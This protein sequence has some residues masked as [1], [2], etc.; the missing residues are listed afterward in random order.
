MDT[1]KDGFSKEDAIAECL[2]EQTIKSFERHSPMTLVSERKGDDEKC[3]SFP[4]R[5][6]DGYFPRIGWRKILAACQDKAD[7]IMECK[8]VRV[9]TT[10]DERLATDNFTH[11]ELVPADA[12]F[13][14]SHD[15]KIDIIDFLLK[16]GASLSTAFGVSLYTIIRCRWRRYA[17]DG[18]CCGFGFK[19]K[20]ED[21]DTKRLT[22]L[23]NENE[24]MKRD[25]NMMKQE[26]EQMRQEMTTQTAYIR[27]T[28][29]TLDRFVDTVDPNRTD[30]GKVESDLKQLR[31]KVNEGFTRLTV[32]YKE[33][34]KNS[35]E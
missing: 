11:V 18:K 6:L 33:L 15:Q 4:N 17:K 24:Q 8:D 3:Q 5:I 7:L 21:P 28:A 14:F 22:K 27:Q 10:V 2:E 25:M 31:G 12:S 9:V 29:E 34:A 16:I 1:C 13:D 32:A 30:I 19:S 35:K 23:E 26:K 20:I